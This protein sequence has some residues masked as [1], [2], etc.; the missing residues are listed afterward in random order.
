MNDLNLKGVPLGNVPQFHK[1]Q[2]IA[3]RIPSVLPK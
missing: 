2:K 1:P 3:Y